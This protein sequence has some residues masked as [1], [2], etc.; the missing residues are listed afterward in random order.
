MPGFS[1]KETILRFRL[2]FIM[3][4]QVY[5]IRGIRGHRILNYHN[6]AQ[7]MKQFILLIYKKEENKE[8]KNKI[9]P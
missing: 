5:C 6:A 7:I 8:N 4:Y 9:S 2:E 1:R 3:L